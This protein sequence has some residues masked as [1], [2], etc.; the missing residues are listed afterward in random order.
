MNQSDNFQTMLDQHQIAEVLTSWGHCR[1]KDEWDTLASCFHEDATIHISWISGSAKDFIERSKKMNAEHLP[2]EHAKHFIGGARVRVNGMRAVSECH[3]DLMTRQFVDGY[4]FDFE[5]WSRFLDLFEKRDGV[6][7]IS[8]RTAIYE[9][10]RMDAV[11]PE[12][13]PESFYALMELDGFPLECRFHCFRQE[14]RGWQSMKDIV[15][16]G[17]KQEAEVRGQAED[18]L[19]A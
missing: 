8:N 13:V 1:D 6:W 9:K 17:G 2:G 12:T 10:D 4:E 11:R 19:R 14:K 15:S 5:V 7:R 18:W 3:V 16:S